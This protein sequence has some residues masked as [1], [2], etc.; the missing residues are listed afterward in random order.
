MLSFAGCESSSGSSGSG[1]SGGGSSS[2]GSS[3]GGGSTGT[4]T[5]EPKTCRGDISTCDPG[6]N[7]RC[8]FAD[9]CF[10]DGSSCFTPGNGSM[11][12]CTADTDCASGFCMPCGTGWSI[13]RDLGCSDTSCGPAYTCSSDNHCVLR[14]CQADT[15]CPE[16]HRCDP[17]EHTCARK[18]CQTDGDCAGYCIS[19]FCTE[20]LGECVLCI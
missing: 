3:G 6:G 18:P 15:D 7:T 2:S 19:G 13:C 1:G 12:R 5:G 11:M 4:T 10:G 20:K 9:G 17:S 14:A 8:F 16:N